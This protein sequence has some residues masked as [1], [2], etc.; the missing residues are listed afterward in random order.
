MMKRQN[1]PWQSYIQIEPDLH[2]GEPCIRGTRIP[3]AVIL[4]NLA[5][6]LS[7]PDLLREYPALQEEHVR[8]ALAYAAEVLNHD[9]VLL[10]LA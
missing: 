4:A 3:V 1:I 7:I 8:A 6:G 9:W 10:P 2:H 5:E